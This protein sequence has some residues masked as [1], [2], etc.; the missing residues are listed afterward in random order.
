MQKFTNRSK[1]YVASA[2]T[3]LGIT[4]LKICAQ[5]LTARNRNYLVEPVRKQSKSAVLRSEP[6]VPILVHTRSTCPELA[7]SGTV[8]GHRNHVA[9]TQNYCYVE[10]CVI[11]TKKYINQY[12]VTLKQNLCLVGALI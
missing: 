1:E 8:R 5:A 9:R 12:E 6:S 4:E 7:N 2:G 11:N 10:I 3:G